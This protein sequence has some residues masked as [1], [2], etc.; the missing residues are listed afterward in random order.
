[1]SIAREPDSSLLRPTWVEIDVAA[2]K[3]NLRAARKMIPDSS[4]L[5]VVLKA[6]AYGHGALS[7]ARLCEEERVDMLAVAILEEAI[8]LR[9]AGI[10]LP[11]LVMGP[12]HAGQLDEAIERHFLLGVVGP[13]ELEIVSAAATRRN[14]PVHIHLK[15][16]SGMGRMGLVE[17]DLER[18]AATLNAQPLVQ[19]EAIYTHFANA[20]DP[21]DPHTEKQQRRFNS[22][23]QRLRELGVSAPLHH[24]ANSAATVRHLVAAGDFARVG[25][26]LYGVESLEVGQSRLEPLM[27]WS[28]RVARIKE[29]A[30]GEGV[31]Y[32]TTFIARRP[33]RVATLPVGYADGYNRLLSN[34]GSVLLCG[35]RA[36]V[37]GRVSMDLVTI[38]VTDIPEVKLG[39][40]VVLLGRQGSEE[41]TAE[42]IATLTGTI[43][44]EVFCAV[45]ARVPRIYREG[46]DVR[47]VRSKF[48]Q[49]L[50]SEPT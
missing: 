3:R 12:L 28:T 48:V 50:E 7:L 19:V 33:T 6:D 20:S 21:G 45:S 26:L 24:S 32:G 27:R 2:F 17:T 1:M 36:P 25:I 30:A 13:E 41:I 44:Y 46:D 5:I 14:E 47:V 4:R 10:E 38:D 8:E 34:R 11:I 22:M 15:L 43:S 18:A 40:E 29:I 31:G 37:I 42:E 16:D 39:D 23:L 35:R 9:A 49:A